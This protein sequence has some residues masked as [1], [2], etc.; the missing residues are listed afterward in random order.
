MTERQALK[1][2]LNTPIRCKDN[3]AEY[4]KA[5]HMAMSALDKQIPKEPIEDGYYD[6]PCVCPTCG[7]PLNYVERVKRCGT[8]GQSILWDGDTEC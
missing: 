7:Q 1:I 2:L 4:S 5:L 6:E 3:H 8:C